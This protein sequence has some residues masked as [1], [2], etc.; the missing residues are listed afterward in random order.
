MKKKYGFSKRKPRF[1][2]DLAVTSIL[3]TTDVVDETLEAEHEEIFADKALI[4]EEFVEEVIV[5]ESSE[6]QDSLFSKLFGKESNA[7]PKEESE[8]SHRGEEHVVEDYK[9]DYAG[10]L[11]HSVSKETTTITQG[12]VI[13]GNIDSEDGLVLSGS[14][15]GNVTS[16]STM[17]LHQGSSIT[18]NVKA[19]SL[20]STGGHI[21]GD[22]TIKGELVLDAKSTI[23]G[24]IQAESAHISGH[25]EGPVSVKGAVVLTS[26]AQINGDLSASSIVVESGAS[27]NGSYTVTPAKKS[28]SLPIYEPVNEVVDTELN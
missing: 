8:L 12:F 9:N 18:G 13:R 20:T 19:S 16:A 23:V 6:K 24:A 2:S 21:Q 25:V 14:I 3:E 17:D 27:L 10:N 22:V 15:E 4:E 1:V 7:L 5:K 26:T 28:T 11:N